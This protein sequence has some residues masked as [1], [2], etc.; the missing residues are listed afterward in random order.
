MFRLLVE[1]GASL[2]AL[3][4]RNMAVLHEAVE[5]GNFEML[6]LILSFPDSIKVLDTADAQRKN[7]YPIKF[8]SVSLTFLLL[9]S[10]TRLAG[11]S[12]S[13]CCHPCKGSCHPKNDEG[14][15]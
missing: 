4:T 5:A 10:N 11:R 15:P 3:T 9:R 7:V 6:K 12:Q 1:H 8:N 14:K 2:I 13:R